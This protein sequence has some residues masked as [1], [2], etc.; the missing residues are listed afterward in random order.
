MVVCMYVTVLKMQ[1]SLLLW[2]V[3]NA[4]CLNNILNFFFFYYLKDSGQIRLKIYCKENQAVIQKRDKI[5][6]NKLAI[7]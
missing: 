2:S 1:Q 7:V 6:K 3:D 4:F 5:F